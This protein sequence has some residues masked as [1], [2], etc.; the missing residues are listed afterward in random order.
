MGNCCRI[1][2]KADLQQVVDKVLFHR[3]VQAFG[4]NPIV[5]ATKSHF[6][7]V[8]KDLLDHVEINLMNS[9]TDVANQL[10]GLADN[11][12]VQDLDGYGIEKYFTIKL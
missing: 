6:S 7:H 4:A 10:K 5:P 1:F 8:R 12:I 2:I 3:S 9:I 11:C